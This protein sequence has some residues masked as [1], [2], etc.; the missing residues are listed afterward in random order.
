MLDEDVCHISVPASAYVS[1][2]SVPTL[3]DVIKKRGSKTGEL[4]IENGKVRFAERAVAK[5]N[6]YSSNRKRNDSLIFVAPPSANLPANCHTV[7]FAQ[8]QLFL[9]LS[10]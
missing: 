7:W 4:T 8:V 6:F 2:V 10:I 9:L 5:A 3:P 1:R